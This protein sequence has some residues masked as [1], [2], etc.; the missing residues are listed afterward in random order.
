M[1]IK[2]CQQPE[3]LGLWMISESR[4]RFERAAKAGVMALPALIA[5]LL[6][7]MSSPA[8][9]RHFHHAIGYGPTD[10]AK[11]AAL[12]VDG[13]TGK[14]L[15]ARNAEAE[16]HPASLTKMMTLY[17]LF[18]ALKKRQMTLETQLVFSSHAAS[19]KPTNMRVGAGETIDADTA[20]RA[21]V[22]RSA[23][24]VAVAVA[25]SIGGTEAHFA[26]MM[27]AKARALGMRNTFFHNASGLPDPMQITTA[28]DLAILARHL[29][30]DF[31]QYFPYFATTD[32]TFRDTRYVGHD[33][34]LGSYDGADGMKTGY[35]Q[36]SGFNLVSSVVR[37]GSHVIG[38][39]MGG[40]TA[41]RRDAEMM[42]LLD[43]AF[44]RAK[45]NPTMLARTQLPWQTVAQNTYSA[46]SQNAS[47]S[48][49]RTVVSDADDEDSAESRSDETDTPDAA[50]PPKP[51]VVASYQPPKPA[52]PKP[53]LRPQA[54]EGDIGDNGT[55]LPVLSMHDWT[56]QIGAFA[57]L[58]QARAQLADYAEKSMD[59]LGQAQRIIVPFQ[60]IDGQLLYRARF[61][62]F[63]EREARQV[64][65]RLTERGQTCFAAISAR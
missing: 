44:G 6:L 26:E 30:Y 47:L 23:N 14:V 55:P 43:D 16:R 19:Q 1:V 21:I 45:S 36:A 49:A 22:V 51:V 18:D 65:A 50:P 27:T 13:E 57:D 10:P 15:Y 34:L 56:I 2:L 59:I 20:I 28:G 64:C 12:I 54:G 7:A 5:A 37:N 25:E 46:V 58:T 38:V 42:R 8:E 31:P 35:T 61:G 39:V 3:G 63:L 40:R 29:A 11:D 24:D 48:A 53:A 41:H 32:F 62:P 33:N 17:L 9:A 4:D 60:A 52:I